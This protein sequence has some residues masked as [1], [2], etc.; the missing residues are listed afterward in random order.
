MT[1]DFSH[2]GLQ[3]GCLDFTR[4]ETPATSGDA[5]DVPEITSTLLPVPMPA[6]AMVSPG[7]VTSGF[8]TLIEPWVPREENDDSVSLIAGVMSLI[9]AWLAPSKVTSSVP[10]STAGVSRSV[11]ALGSWITGMTLL[12][13]MPAAKTS[14]F[15]VKIAPTAPA[16]ATLAERA[17]DPHW[18]VASLSSQ[19]SQATLSLTAAA[20]VSV[21]GSQPSLLLTPG[22]KAPGIFTTAPVTGSPV[23]PLVAQG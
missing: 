12:P 15:E 17:T 5:I 21:S 18:R 20:S 9:V 22:P 4:A 2:S 7:A 6:D 13:V 23:G 8:T 19:Y 11:C 14:K 1:A 3:S 10:A 16:A